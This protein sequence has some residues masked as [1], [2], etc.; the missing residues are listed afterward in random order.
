[1]VL[2]LIAVAAAKLIMP[3]M[4]LLMAIP[5]LQRQLQYGSNN[6]VPNQRP[7][8]QDVIVYRRRGMID[9]E[10]YYAIMK[11]YGYQEYR[12][13]E[14]YV[15]SRRVVDAGELI[16]LLRR[17]EIDEGVFAS[18][19]SEVGF[20]ERER[21]ILLKA[22][23]FYPS[24]QDLIVWQAR[25]VFEPDSVEKYG[26]DDEL[27]LIQREAFYKAGID[28]EQIR[29]YWIAHWQHPG[30]TVVREML[31]RTDLTEADVHEWFRLVEIPPYWREKYTE[32]MY[33][34]YSRVDVRRM[35]AAGI[36][37]YDE[38]VEAYRELG[39]KED[40]ARNLADFAVSTTLPAERDLTRAQI[41]K[42]FE[43]GILD[44]VGA[45]ELLQDMGYDELEADYILTLKEVKMDDEVEGHKID[46][47]MDLYK[48]GALDQET[49]ISELNALNLQASYRDKLVAK[50]MRV[51]AAEVRMPSKAELERWLKEDLID[52]EKWTNEMGALGYRAAD[53]LNYR[54][55]IRFDMFDELEAKAREADPKLLPRTVITSMYV[56]GIVDETRLRKGFMD[57]HFLDV[58]IELLV[59]QADLKRAKVEEKV[60]TEAAKEEESEVE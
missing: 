38:V 25:E 18:L 39:Y 31:H 56:A 29:N 16:T 60:A 15:A 8:P 47:L 22:T 21:E 14:L 44:R 17:G 7:G 49:L 13:E 12:A 43:E 33:Q 42:G 1:M 24:A 45:M 6:L 52:D 51:K 3:S 57:L 5:P 37:D 58:D 53:I 34:P 4:G 36:L 46:V 50:A 28:D 40:K 10:K 2:P 26:L 32:I 48:V 11:L 41:E 54:E 35:Y 27:D 23:M 30:W 19:M 59:A 20:E 55:E 9:E